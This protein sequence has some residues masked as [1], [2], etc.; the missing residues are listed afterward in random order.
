M[1]NIRVMFREM[2]SATTI[3]SATQIQHNIH[4]QQKLLQHNNFST[5]GNRKSTYTLVSLRNDA[6]GHRVLCCAA[7]TILGMEG[8]HKDQGLLLPQVWEGILG[9]FG[10]SVEAARFDAF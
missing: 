4:G 8:M 10:M 6:V 5:V 3:Y 2:S 1:H 9:N 7:A